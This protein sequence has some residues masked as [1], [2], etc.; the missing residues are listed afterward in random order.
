MDFL[1]ILRIALRALAR[2]KMR[3]LLTMLGIVIG[4][5]AVITLVGIG[6][7]ADQTMQKQIASLGSNMLYVTSGSARFG[8]VRLGSGNTKTLVQSDV[9]AILKECPAVV[10]A[11]P[12]TQ[13]SAQVVFGN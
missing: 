3:S 7:G 12:G 5:G 6:E 2:N 8:G 11:A 10:A 1:S 4:V 13:T 9:I